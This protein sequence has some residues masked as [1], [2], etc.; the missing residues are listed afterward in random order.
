MVKSVIF[1]SLYFSAQR[2]LAGAIEHG[3]LRMAV[4]SGLWIHFGKLQ[5]FCW[6]VT[7]D[8]GPWESTTPGYHGAG[9]FLLDTQGK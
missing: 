7:K 8:F 9:L 1:V 5:D 4:G 6:V 3:L 2:Y